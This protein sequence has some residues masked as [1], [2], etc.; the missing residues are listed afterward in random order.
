MRIN[1]LALLATALFISS[2]S[3]TRDYPPH[4]PTKTGQTFTI[5]NAKGEMLF[6]VTAPIGYWT[7]NDWTKEKATKTF[8]FN[9]KGPSSGMIN[10]EIRIM[11]VNAEINITGESL[12]SFKQRTTTASLERTVSN[13]ANNVNFQSF[14]KP[15]NLV[16]E[17][18]TIAGINCAYH[19]FLNHSGPKIG[20][21]HV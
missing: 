21:A 10:A 3:T 7:L 17:V 15:K 8:F 12:E 2:C 6:D 20:R 14:H 9:Y 5:S 4:I 19:S 16:T 1:V 11:Y 13:L 18:R